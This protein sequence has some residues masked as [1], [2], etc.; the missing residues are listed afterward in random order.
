MAKFRNII[1]IL[2]NNVPFVVAVGEGFNF[3]AYAFAPAS[4]VTPLGALSIL[5]AAVLAQKFLQE[6]LNIFG[7]VLPTFLY[8]HFL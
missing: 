8:I 6:K 3:A 5:V 7:K 4:L 2:K 1:F